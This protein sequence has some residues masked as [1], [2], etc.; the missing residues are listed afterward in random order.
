M[1]P[2]SK[3]EFAHRCSHSDCGAELQGWDYAIHEANRLITAANDKIERLNHS[4][5]AFEQMRDSGE[6]WPGTFESEDGLLGQK[7]DMG[8]SPTFQ[9]ST[10]QSSIFH[11]F[12]LSRRAQSC[13]LLE[14]V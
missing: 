8:Q 1:K 10:F 3:E 2:K 13:G 11:S 12:K 9:P 14:L 5:R 4:I 7:G 6:P